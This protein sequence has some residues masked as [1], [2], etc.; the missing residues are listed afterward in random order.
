MDIETMK[1]RVKELVEKIDSSDN[2][3]E[4]MSELSEKHELEMKIKGIEPDYEQ[5]DCLYC[6]G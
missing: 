3:F 4:V 6:S 2:M 5:D 1:D